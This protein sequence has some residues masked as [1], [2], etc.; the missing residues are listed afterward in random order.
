MFCLDIE[1]SLNRQKPLARW[2]GLW[3][4]LVLGASV[5]SCDNGSSS[6]KAQRVARPAEGVVPVKVVKTAHGFQLLRGGQ[7]YFLR[8]AGGLQQ[9]EQLRQAGGNTVRLWSADY[10]GPLLDKAQQQGLSVMLGLWIERESPHFSYYDP[11]M[12]Q[13]QLS[14]VRAQVLR[15]RHHPALLMWN[16]GNEVESSVSGP[17]LFEAVD[18]IARMIHE[19]DPYHPV[20]MSLESM[21][22]ASQLQNIAPN[23]NVLSINTY[24]KLDRL[25]ALMKSSGWRGP[26]I[27]TEYGNRGYWESDSTSW[28]ASF[29]QTSA[30]KA[31]FMAARYRRVIV[32]DSTH[33]LGSYVFYWGTKFE[34]T[35]TWFSLFEP[36]GEKTELV[37]ELHLLWQRRYPTNRAPHLTGLSLAG[38]QPSDNVRVRPGQHCPAVATVTDPEGDT[39]TTRWEVLPEMPPGSDTKTITSPLELVAGCV[40]QA[41]GQQAT[42][43]APQRPGAYRLYVRVFDGHGSVGTANFPFLVRRPAVRSVYSAATTSD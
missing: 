27:V 40:V 31:D 28:K 25:P 3:L 43:R 29:E 18:G 14:R 23:V 19:L 30:Q 36:T 10:A 9:F 37:D 7:P 33:C 22:K 24:G 2:A 26:Y 20:T 8:G 5:G 17:R 42:I 13:E 39:L 41:S 16:V 4:L 35:P 12:V 11:A 21:A 1:K 32:A 34:Y 6:Q 38:R 15:Y